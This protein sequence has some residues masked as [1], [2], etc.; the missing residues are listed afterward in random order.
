MHGNQS[1]SSVNWQLIVYSRMFGKNVNTLL[2]KWNNRIPRH[3]FLGY[4]KLVHTVRRRS[5][6]KAVYWN[7]CYHDFWS[8]DERQNLCPV[9]RLASILGR[10]CWF[11][12]VHVYM[13]WISIGVPCNI[14]MP[15]YL[16]HFKTVCICFVNADW[17]A[18]NKPIWAKTWA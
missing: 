18:D 1:Y 4:L 3:F 5:S 11:L 6:V 14:P 13:L 16:C 7:N 12:Y 9:S 10:K 17:T 15:A 8:G 2:F